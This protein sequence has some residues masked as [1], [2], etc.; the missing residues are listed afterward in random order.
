MLHDFP[1]KCKLYSKQMAKIY[2]GT[3][4]ARVC[5]YLV[6]ILNKQIK[7]NNMVIMRTVSNINYDLT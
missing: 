2:A 3:N 5:K 4:Y 1:N 6:I 7:M